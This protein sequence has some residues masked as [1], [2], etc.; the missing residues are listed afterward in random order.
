MPATMRAATK[1]PPQAKST[2]AKVP[3][4]VIH[5]KRIRNTGSHC[6]RLNRHR[7]ACACPASEDTAPRGE[8][9][10][11]HC[12]FQARSPRLIGSQPAQA[13]PRRADSCPANTG[14]I[15]DRKCRPPATG[16]VTRTVVSADATQYNLSLS[17]TLHIRWMV[18]PTPM[19]SGSDAYAA[20]M[21][22]GMLQE[23]SLS[24]YT[25]FRASDLAIIKE[26]RTL[27]VHGSAATTAGTYNASY[28]ATIMTD[29]DPA[30]DVWSFPLQAN[31]TWNVTGNATVHG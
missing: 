7:E 5:R 22:A 11:N 16:S 1:T 2:E 30:L 21:A 27:E 9:T 6:Q 4:K 20:S 13:T 3:M 8:R 28:V 29:F 15:T 10:D 14:Q 24:G 17:G 19:A 18:D 26:V 23:A 12:R 25:S 31:E